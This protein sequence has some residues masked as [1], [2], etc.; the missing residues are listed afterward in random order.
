MRWLTRRRPFCFKDPRFCYTLDAW[1]PALGDAVFICVFREP[2][3][4]ASS[5]IADI[6]ERGYKLRLSRRRALRIW[7]LMYEH[8]L[9]RH[10]HRGQW[11]FVHYDQFLDG[12]AIPRV[13]ALLEA[14]I[15]SGFVDPQLKRSTGSLDVPRRTLEAYNELCTLAGQGDGTPHRAGAQP[16]RRSV[17][18]PA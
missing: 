7:T 14:K 15:D 11:L 13:E 16:G 9:K 4:T 8:I 17:C 5:M 3:R 12:S 2:G 6:R 18:S 10:L 1:R